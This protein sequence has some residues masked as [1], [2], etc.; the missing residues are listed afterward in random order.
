MSTSAAF[1]CLSWFATSTATAHAQWYASADFLLMNR[2]DNASDE[3][4]RW[5]AR[6]CNPDSTR[7]T[8]CHG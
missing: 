7:S 5:Q 8:R 3:T 4:L 2:S 1:E 6:T